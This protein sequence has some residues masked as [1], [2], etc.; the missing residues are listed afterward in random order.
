M[1]SHLVFDKESKIYYIQCP[2]CSGFISINKKDI[3]CKLF[4]HAVLIKTGKNI[5]PHISKNKCEQL[6]K[7]A[8]IFG[9]GNYF[10]FDGEKI[11][12]VN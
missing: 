11:E 6:I 3:K 1:D 8:K 12:K 10:K 5:N 4:L 7:S 9:C 2:Y